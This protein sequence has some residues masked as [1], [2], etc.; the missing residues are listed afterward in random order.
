MASTQV[1]L[2]AASIEISACF[3]SIPSQLLEKQADFFVA[4]EFQPVCCC[5]TKGQS[6]S[7]PWSYGTL[8]HSRG[9]RS[10]Q[11]SRSWLDFAGRGSAET[12]TFSWMDDTDS[13][14]SVKQRPSCPR[15]ACQVE[16]AHGNPSVVPGCLVLNI[17][18]QKVQKPQTTIGHGRCTIQS[19]GDIFDGRPRML[20]V[21]L[22]SVNCI[23]FPIHFTFRCERNR[24]EM[25][26]AP[27]VICADDHPIRNDTATDFPQRTSDVGWNLSG[28]LPQMLQ[29]TGGN[30]Q[31]HSRLRTQ[32]LA[33]PA[34]TVHSH[35]HSS[36][37]PR[38]V[39]L[40]TQQKTP[41][42][43]PQ[44]SNAHN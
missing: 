6:K 41:P 21:T 7:T 22:H 10:K 14:L 17:K 30:T 19:D 5:P 13:Y 11:P 24:K 33:S 36:V 1:M 28:F 38:A 32:S 8:I 9:A 34:Q 3:S 26:P 29:I 23:S 35:S 15:C 40:N 2:E 25:D 39:S 43:L 37:R 27:M 44:R 42:N 12:R 20:Q 18:I 31:S 16:D 4:F